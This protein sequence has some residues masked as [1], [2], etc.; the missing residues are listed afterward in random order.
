MSQYPSLENILSS[1]FSVQ[2]GLE[3]D[4]ASAAFRRALASSPK[5]EAEIRAA[6]ADPS[7]SWTKL[8]FNDDYEVYEADSE[9]DARQFASEIL[10]HE[11]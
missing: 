5:L 7:I 8:L 10:E 11:I 4:D 2:T 3:D 1:L 9:Q 6:F